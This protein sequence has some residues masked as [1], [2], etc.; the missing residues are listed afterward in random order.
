MGVCICVHVCVCKC[1]SAFLCVCVCVYLN[2]HQCVLLLPRSI[3]SITNN[4]SALSVHAYVRL[5]DPWVCMIIKFATREVS[6]FFLQH[7]YPGTHDNLFLY[8]I[9]LFIHLFVY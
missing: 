2:M 8:F 7:V 5:I 4:L 3:A 9:Y 6:P 1:A